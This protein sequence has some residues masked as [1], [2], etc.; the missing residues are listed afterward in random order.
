MMIAF[1]IF[2]SYIIMLGMIIGD[3]NKCVKISRLVWLSWIFS[4]ITLP[5]ILGMMI[6][7]LAEI[8]ENE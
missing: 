1:Y 4:P 3:S 5:L 2:L 8:K 6:I 7:T